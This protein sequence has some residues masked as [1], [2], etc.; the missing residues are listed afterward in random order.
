VGRESLKLEPV[1]VVAEVAR[2]DSGS[3]VIHLRPNREGIDAV[4]VNDGIDAIY[5][6]REIPL[7]QLEAGDILAMSVKED[8]PGRYRSGFLTIR[9]RRGKWD[10]AK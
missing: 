7:E 10:A 5:L 1:E 8:P 3:R 2:V 9:D 6:G 4:F